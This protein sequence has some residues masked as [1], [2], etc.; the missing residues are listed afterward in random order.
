MAN[1]DTLL[2]WLENAHSMET[3]IAQ[4]L[5]RHADDAKNEPELAA[6]IREH[7]AKT[8]LHARAMEKA[9]ARLGGAVSAVKTGLASVMGAVEGAATGFAS[10]WMVRNAVAE[11]SAE[12]FEMATYKAII[13]AAEEAGD[14]ETVNVCLDI[15]KEEE[16]MAAW[17]ESELP[18]L[19]AEFMRREKIA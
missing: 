9:V 8:Q 5:E 6:K 7:L 10:D 17:L 2:R 3:A 19:V 11:Y 1:K 18:E 12:Y 16:E 4:T 15:L 14:Q 13:A